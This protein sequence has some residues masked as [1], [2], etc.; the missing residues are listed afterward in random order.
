[1]SESSEPAV[2]EPTEADERRSVELTRRAQD[3][4]LRGTPYGDERCRTCVYYLDAD[5]DFSY[6]WHP[7]LALL[8]DQNWWCQWWEETE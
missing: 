3:A 4:A 2:P 5:S 8:V 7:N 1:M 6:C